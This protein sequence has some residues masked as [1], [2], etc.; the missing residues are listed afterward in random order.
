MM[1]PLTTGV[2]ITFRSASRRVVVFVSAFVYLSSVESVDK[3]T[4][5]IRSKIGR[6]E[7]KEWAYKFV[8]RLSPGIFVKYALTTWRSI[9]S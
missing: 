1:R 4:C 8:T 5:G 9:K 7:E 6:R 2:T 3:D